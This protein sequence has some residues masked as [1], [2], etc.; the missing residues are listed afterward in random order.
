MCKCGRG[1]SPRLLINSSSA[2]EVSRTVWSKCITEK[3]DP[4]CV[5]PALPFFLRFADL[6]ISAPLANPGSSESQHLVRGTLP[7]NILH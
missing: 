6:A 2:C 1:G 5:R 3:R 7:S 4:R